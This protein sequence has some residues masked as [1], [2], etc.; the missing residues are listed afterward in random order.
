MC[1]GNTMLL[2]ALLLFLNQFQRHGRDSTVTRGYLIGV[3]GGVRD[4]SQRD[5]NNED[6]AAHFIYYPAQASTNSHE[7]PMLDRVG[8]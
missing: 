4:Y 2:A 5:L 1:R 7:A 3:I 8:Q 6:L